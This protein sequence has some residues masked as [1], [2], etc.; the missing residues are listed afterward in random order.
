MHHISSGDTASLLTSAALVMFMT[1]GLAFFYGRLV[2]A[3]NGYDDSL[4]VV[5]VH[6]VGG[7]LG[8]LLTGAFVHARRAD[9]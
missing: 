9:G 3:K 7:V 4:D 2:R 8:V 5:G 1:P 6:L